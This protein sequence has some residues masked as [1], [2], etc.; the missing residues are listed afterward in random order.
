VS[1]DADTS[2]DADRS[3]DAEGSDDVDDAKLEVAGAVIY[4]QRIALPA[5][6][7]LTVRVSDVSLADAPATV[8]AEQVVTADRQVPIPF[9]LLLDADALEDD[10]R[11]S[12]SAQIHIDGELRWTTDTHVP[13]TATAPMTDVQLLV[14]PASSPSG[15]PDR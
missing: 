13:V 14:V 6:A 3:D 12:L 4:R 8:V 11:Y 1:D 15:R 9:R 10:R 7:V 5:G 2:D